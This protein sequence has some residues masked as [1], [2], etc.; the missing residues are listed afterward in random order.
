VVL[1]ALLGALLGVAVSWL[2]AT[3][4]EMHRVS[5]RIGRI[6]GAFSQPEAERPSRPASAAGS[7]NVLIAGLDGERKTGLVLGS[8]TDAIIVLHLDADRSRAWLTSIPRDSWVTLPGFGQ[9]KVNAA[10]PIGGPSL[11]VRTVEQLTGIRMD[12]LVVIDWTG[13]R[14][15]TDG[16]GGVAVSLGARTRSLPDSTRAS[17]AYHMSGPVALDYVRERATLPAGDLD[18]VHR[19][20]HYL[21]ALIGQMLERRLLTDATALR[22]LATGI[23]DAV[24]VDSGFTTSQML[25]LAASMQ[26]L[27]ADDVTFLT[28]P[29][30][31]VGQEGEATVGRFDKP[32]GDHLW[33]AMAS[34][35]MPAFLAEH[36]E[37]VTA[38]HVR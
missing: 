34:D 20:Q 3:W 2:A 22:A 16:V 26:R 6:P 8:R 4:Y 11:F 24:R 27:T 30:T 33:H 35:S 21:R 5:H 10:Y 9:N 36:P 37:L 18:R 1:V 31:G 29:V 23:G 25:S 19:Q 14:R 32:L 7:M 13:F 38:Q 15:L 28:A 12:H 17:V